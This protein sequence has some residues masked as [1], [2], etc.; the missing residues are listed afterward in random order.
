[1][2]AWKPAFQ[3]GLDVDFMLL[4]DLTIENGNVININQNE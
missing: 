4:L 2:P 1:M 3:N